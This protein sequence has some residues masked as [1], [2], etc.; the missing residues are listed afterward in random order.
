M[1]RKLERKTALN[2]LRFNSSPFK[3]GVYKIKAFKVSTPAGNME[4]TEVKNNPDKYWIESE[5]DHVSVKT[6]D[7]MVIV[8]YIENLDYVATS[9]E[10]PPEN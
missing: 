9:E 4:Y 10:T 5:R 7:V 1:N 6:D 8:R 3:N 2:I